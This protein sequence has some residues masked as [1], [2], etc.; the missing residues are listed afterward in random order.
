MKSMMTGT[1]CKA[2]E[3]A[4]I[5]SDTC[6]EITRDATIRTVLGLVE[7]KINGFSSECHL[8]ELCIFTIMKLPFLSWLQY[9][10]HSISNCACHWNC[11]LCKI[12]CTIQIAIP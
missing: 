9:I 6:A 5:L 1:F 12:M 8:Y 11:F 4:S 3:L 10:F 2:V 7:Q